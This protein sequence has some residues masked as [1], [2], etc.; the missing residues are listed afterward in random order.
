MTPDVVVDIGNSR[1]KWGRCEGDRIRG[2]ATLGHGKPDRWAAKIADWVPARPVRWAVAGVHPGHLD[3]FVGWAKARGNSVTVIENW[4]QINL[5]LAVDE[6]DKVGIDRL[7]TTLAACRRRPGELP[8]A[9]VNVGTAI[10]VDFVNTDRVFIGGAIL[11]GPRLMARSLRAHTAKLPLVDPKPLPPDWYFGA[12][13]VEAI[14][15]GIKAAVVGAADHL[16]QEFGAD[17]AQ[18]VTV[19]IT[20]GGLGYFG[21]HLF[22]ADTREV[23]FERRLTLEGI[24]IA[25]EGLP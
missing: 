19:F 16:I 21:D 3:Q 23:V 9:V 18:P 13:T 25:A 5:P 8:L 4:Q 11:P 15:V 7:A 6:P 14:E 2:M 10:T 17:S 1:M 12:N 20:G 22:I 24:R